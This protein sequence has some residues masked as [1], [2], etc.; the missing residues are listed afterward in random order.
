M[1]VLDS[2]LVWADKNRGRC[3]RNLTS[4]LSIPSISAQPEHA[5]DIVVAAQWA[6]DYLR[7]LGLAVEIV[8]TAQHPCVLATTPEGLYP[9]GA[10]HVLIYGHYDVQPPEPLELW[11]SPPF[12]PTVRGEEL[13]AR[14]ACDDKGQVH[15]HLAALMAWKEINHG[16]PCRITLLLE[17]EEEIGSPNLMTVVRAKREMLQ[18]AKVLLISDTNMFADGVPSITYGLRGLIGV[19][20]AL[21]GAKTDLHSGMYG[22]TVANPA[23]ALCAMIA[24]LHDAAGRITVPGFYDD[25]Q[26]LT[27]AEQAMWRQ[28]PHDD[29]R[30]AAELGV[31]ELFGEG[32]FSTL[33]RK[34][35][36]P[37]LEVNGL[38]SGYQGPGGKTVLPNRASVKIT[39]RLVPNQDPEKLGGALVAYLQSL[40]PPGVTFELISQSTGS[41]PAITPIDSAAMAAASEAMEM[42]FG[43]KPVFQRE[44]GSIP[45]VAWFKQA[46]AIDAVL[47]GFGLPDDRIHAPN[48][49]I[50]L[51]YY[52]G[53]IKCCAAMYELLAQRLK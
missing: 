4:F 34:W 20:F 47:L 9:P 17:G 12:T 42:A 46:L 41:P 45:V 37:T 24:K 10:P 19:E 48:E 5:R 44:G 1:S 35:A 29:A 52:Y 32:G 7:T 27:E 39:C 13:F 22:G 51:R 49:K 16:F 28:L 18:D 2:V 8:P 23:H 3:L 30:Y 50:D 53:G 21:H 15:C 33:E 43:K 11:T 25:V 6:A 40:V 31:K 14:G 38:T 36:R 26:P